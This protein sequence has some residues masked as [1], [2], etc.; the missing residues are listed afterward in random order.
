MSWGYC[1][2]PRMAATPNRGVI[3]SDAGEHGCRPSR[4]HA[5]FSL[6]GERESTTSCLPRG[7]RPLAPHDRPSERAGGGLALEDEAS[8]TRTPTAKR[9]PVDRRMGARSVRCSR[10]QCRVSHQHVDD[11]TFGYGTAV[12]LRR[13]VLE[14]HRQLLEISDLAPDVGEVLE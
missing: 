11:R 4:Y 6:C 12:A 3:A 10:R 2:P 7:L 1:S 9:G 8:P 14:E 5:A 13:H